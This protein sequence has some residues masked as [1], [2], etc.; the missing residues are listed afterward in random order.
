MLA[1]GAN[2]KE[3]NLATSDLEMDVKGEQW[4]KGQQQKNLLLNLVSKVE[5]IPKIIN[6]S[7]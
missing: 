2:K 1:A 3:E 7:Y 4:A 6:G 5:T